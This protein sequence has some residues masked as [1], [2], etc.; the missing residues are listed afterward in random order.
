MA[1]ENKSWVLVD[2]DESMDGILGALQMVIRHQMEM[3]QTMQCLLSDISNHMQS[4]KDEIT[5]LREQV[6]DLENKVIARDVRT[7]NR[8]IRTGV[9]FTFNSAKNQLP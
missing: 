1:E 4:V 8:S 2:I 7:V 9:P 3:A 6:V 5:T